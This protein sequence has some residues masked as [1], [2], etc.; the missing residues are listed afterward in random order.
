M[1]VLDTTALVYAK[2]VDH[3]L[4]EPCRRLIRATADGT[5]EAT[6]TIEAIQEFVHVRARRRGRA[7]AAA[8]GRDH[9]ELLS[10]LR[11]VEGEDLR[12]GL[13]LFERHDV[14]GA[15]DAVLA[16][17]ALRAGA[18]ALVSGG[19]AFAAVPGLVHLV[20]DA[21]GVDRLLA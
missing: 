7:D 3:A 19:R 15:F 6:T 18:T 20:P 14:L 12:R 1:I 16:A 11:A 10:L 4:R 8:L 2:G 17:T 13:D 21:A 5:L 9:A